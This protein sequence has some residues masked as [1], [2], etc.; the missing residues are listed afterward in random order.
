M[1]GKTSASAAAVI[2]AATAATWSSAACR[3]PTARAMSGS[4]AEGRA[5]CRAALYRSAAAVEEAAQ[6]GRRGLH[7][8][9]QSSH[10]SVL[11]YPSFSEVKH[12]KMYPP[13][14][15][16]PDLG[17]QGKPPRPDEHWWR[18]NAGKTG[19]VAP[20]ARPR[21]A[22]PVKNAVA[23]AK[24]KPWDSEFRVLHPDI[25][26]KSNAEL[27]APLRQR[28]PDFQHKDFAKEPAYGSDPFLQYQHT[29]AGLRE[30]Y[31]RELAMANQA[32]EQNAALKAGRKGALINPEMS[33]EKEEATGRFLPE[34]IETSR[35]LG[36]EHELE[37]LDV[38]GIY[39][40]WRSTGG[41]AVFTLSDGSIY[42][43]DGLDE[44]ITATG[45][46][47]GKRWKSVA[48]TDGS[49]L[50]RAGN[51]ATDADAFRITPKG[52]D[53]ANLP[54]WLIKEGR[55]SNR[56][57]HELRLSRERINVLL[58]LY[59]EADNFVTEENLDEKIEEFYADESRTDGASI[60]ELLLADSGTNEHFVPTKV[61][62]RPR[63]LLDFMEG[64]MLGGKLS[65]D[66]LKQTGSTFTVPETSGR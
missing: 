23:A 35:T 32:R 16:T 59:Y 46:P 52:G 61:V 57:E 63:T 3:P 22:P 53:F 56:K 31:T 41:N 37:T 20:F 8:T 40:P 4:A 36:P 27:R 39:D 9:A 10:E 33:K 51:P 66:G 30:K 65:C 25:L 29:M 60:A 13:T 15:R 47:R 2:G 55:E 38:K 50:G 45:Q 62:E 7:A 49:V 21:K 58:Q 64:T 44:P 54:R 17:R 1:P 34:G 28:L 5:L 42:R 6:P 12:E 48:S 24:A 26:G 14:R 43:N 18:D 19:Y 11:Q